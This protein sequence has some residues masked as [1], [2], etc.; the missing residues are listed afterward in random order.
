MRQI[1]L[2]C[3][4]TLIVSACTGVM[5]RKTSEELASTSDTDLCK[6]YFI[7]I[8][9]RAAT[10]E[11]SKKEQR[12]IF[13]EFERRGVDHKDLPYHCAHLPEGK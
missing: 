3:C 4:I 13:A 1:L 8:D 2:I 11:M 7:T 12:I 5:A 6:Q 10:W 9:P